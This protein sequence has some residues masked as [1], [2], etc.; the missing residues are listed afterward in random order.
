MLQPV[1]FKAGVIR[2]QKKLLL[3]R[4]V[5]GHVEQ[6]LVHDLAKN[7]AGASGLHRVMQIV[8]NGKKPFVFAVDFLDAHTEFV[9]PFRKRHGACSFWALRSF[10]RVTVSEDPGHAPVA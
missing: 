10:A 2:A 1:P 7:L 3:V 8:E 5:I 4:E 9:R 6:Q